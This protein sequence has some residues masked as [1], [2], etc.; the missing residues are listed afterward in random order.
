MT[1]HSKWLQAQ[2][3]AAVAIG[4]NPI[5]AHN[6]AKAFLALLPAD[7][8]PDT[9]IVPA[10]ALEQDVSDPALV[11]DAVNAWAGDEEVATRFKLILLA[12]EA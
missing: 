3:N 5:D 8:D 10:Y 9:Y 1:D 11:Q 4:I 6:A 7:A 12:G 2:V